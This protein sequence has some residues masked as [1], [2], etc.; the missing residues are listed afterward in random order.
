MAAR[1]GA[2]LNERAR[3]RRQLAACMEGSLACGGSP[4]WRRLRHFS[5]RPELIGVGSGK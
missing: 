4:N 3:A 2:S 1:E 5:D